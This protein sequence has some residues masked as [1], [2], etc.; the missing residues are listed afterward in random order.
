MTTFSEGLE[1]IKS[2]IEQAVTRQPD[3]AE[4][5]S[6][7]L[8]DLTK[9]L[10]TLGN[11]VREGLESWKKQDRDDIKDFTKRIQSVNLGL[12]DLKKLIDEY[13]STR[14]V[15]RSA[16]EPI[17]LSEVDVSADTLSQI[18]SL[19]ER[20]PKAV[21]SAPKKPRRLRRR[22]NSVWQRA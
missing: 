2:T 13:M 5:L 3:Q 9:I 18:Y 1:G 14:K 12:A 21:K 20:D 10:A 22:R 17:D 19:I 8:G 6:V 7:D 15:S 16:D 11:D 4:E